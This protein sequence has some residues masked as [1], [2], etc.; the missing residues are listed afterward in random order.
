MCVEIAKNAAPG[1][2]D[3]SELELVPVENQFQLTA[4]T[5]FVFLYNDFRFQ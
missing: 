5:S 3:T 1:T 4:S 2:G